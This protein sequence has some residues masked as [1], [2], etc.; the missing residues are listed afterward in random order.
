MITVFPYLS[1]GS[2]DSTVRTMTS[3]SEAAPNRPPRKKKLRG[4]GSDASGVLRRRS[5]GEDGGGV[6]RRN[7][8]RS[9]KRSGT[10][11][12]QGGPVTVGSLGNP[13]RKKR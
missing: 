1:Q 3:D 4:G 5:N 9:V 8:V 10:L 7:T 13:E 12:K 2:G 11:R 6:A